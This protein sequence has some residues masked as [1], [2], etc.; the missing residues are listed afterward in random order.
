MS[1]W[2]PAVPGWRLLWASSG[3]ERVGWGT[4][5]A[6]H[7]GLTTVGSGSA[8]GVTLAAVGG[9]DGCE[10]FLGLVRWPRCGGGRE[11]LVI[12]SMLFYG[13]TASLGCV[14]SQ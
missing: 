11:S 10:C 4:V 13:M 6:T 3:R 9:Y 2:A 1:V 7:G 5:D 12:G 14:F 8:L